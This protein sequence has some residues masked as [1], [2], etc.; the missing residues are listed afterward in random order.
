MCGP[1][2]NSAICPYCKRYCNDKSRHLHEVGRV[3]WVSL[4][5]CTCHDD[6]DDDD[7]D[8]RERGRA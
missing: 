3:R 4:R 5:C 8:D 7:D 6:D 2:I 1:I